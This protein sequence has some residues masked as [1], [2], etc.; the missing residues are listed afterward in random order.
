MHA[1]INNMNQYDPNYVPQESYFL[2]VVKLIVY[3]KENNILLLQRSKKTPRPL[4]WDFPGGGVDK[5]EDP[6]TAG[7]REV[8]E[9]TGLVV[10]KLNL[11]NTF[12]GNIREEDYVSIGYSAFTEDTNVTLSW[13]HKAHKW[14]TLSRAGDLH[15]PDLHKSLLD[16]FVQYRNVKRI[17]SSSI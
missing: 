6:E 15:L 2:L 7:R 4:G 12:Y 5:G 14:M 10:K 11:L 8:F 3:D 16:S 13:E 1:N 9:E 17:E